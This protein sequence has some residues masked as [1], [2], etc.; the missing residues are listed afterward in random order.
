MILFIAF[1]MSYKQNPVAILIIVSIGMG[2]YSLTKVYKRKRI[3]ESGVISKGKKT[4][5]SN[6]NDLLT[7]FMLSQA[8]RQDKS[9]ELQKN[10]NYYLDDNDQSKKDNIEQTKQIITALLEKDY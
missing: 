2:L 4:S 10:R 1:F 8:F 6:Y 3:G 9:Y 7:I 5:S